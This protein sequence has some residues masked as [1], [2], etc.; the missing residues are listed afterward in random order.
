LSRVTFQPEVNYVVIELFAPQHACQCLALHTALI[1][2]H[3]R[4][5]ESSVKLACFLPPCIED[6]IEV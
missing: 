6:R 3:S 4:G 5:L 2:V 1:L